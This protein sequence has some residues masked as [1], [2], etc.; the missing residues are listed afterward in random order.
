MAVV[1]RR[2]SVAATKIRHQVALDGALDGDN[3][4]FMI[5]NGEKA[6]HNPTGGIKA[7]P[8]H[9][10]RRLLD[11]EFVMEESGGPGTGFNQLRLIAFAPPATSLVFMDFVAA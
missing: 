6:I 10:T 2:R 3:R 8:Y 11:F 1:A 9:G 4:I 5:P 7:R